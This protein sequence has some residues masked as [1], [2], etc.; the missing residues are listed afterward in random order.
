MSPITITLILLL[1]AI[2]LFAIE[3]IPV[4]IVGILLVMGLVLFGVLNVQEAVAGFG[5]D[6]IITIGGLFVLTGG[7][8]KTGL[9]DLFGRRL[10]RIAGDNEFVLVFLI[11]MVGT[12][13]STFMNNTT[14]T[15]ML[16]PFVL[17][18][19]QRSK[20]APSKL[21]MPLAFGTIM[22]GSCL[23]IG[24]S[25]NLAVS[26]ALTRY[27]MEPI[28]MFELTPVGVIVALLGIIYMLVIGRK[29]LPNRGG[30]DSLTEQYNIRDYISEL[31]VLPESP[32]VGK[33][34][35]ETNLNTD[36][37]LNV[38][39]IIRRGAKINA[40]DQNERIQRRDS[41]IVEGSINDILRVKDE[42]GLEIK[43]DFTLNDVVLEDEDTELFEVLVMR[44]SRF[45]GQ[46]LKTLRFR[47]A[48]NLTVL[49]INRHGRTFI[50]KLSAVPF[51][52]GDVLLV[53]GNREGIQ[54]LIA[55]REVMILKDLSEENV[56]SD[57]QK[58]AIL[59]FVVFLSLSLSKTVVGYD[60]PLAI[61][62]LCGVMVLLATKTIRYS[63]MYPMIDFRLLV[64]IACM[65]SFGVA[66]ESS[67]ADTYLADM[68]NL[69][70]G[71]FGPIAVLS[72][73]FILT[74]VL[75]QPMSNQAA[76]LVV[77]PVAIKAAVALG[78]N[79]RTFAIAVTFAASFSFI[80]PLE[81]ACVLVYTPGRYRFMD[82]VKIGS[83][84]TVIVFVV[85][86]VLVPIFWPF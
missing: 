8:V 22:G 55:N 74:V 46:N 75:T 45:V 30:E 52:F 61:A 25:T 42:A 3:K 39:G 67:G 6:I 16:I 49:A 38:L 10:F 57:K 73:F 47:Q 51:I 48:Y 53:Q 50:N 5:N 43:P 24:T 36:L 54:P 21:L 77:L 35:G 64:L 79:P 34:L 9:V 65:M 70:F 72:G 13:S 40:P 14:A 4:D 19:A 11:M 78:L 37:D 80:T 86:M 41:L 31:L 69:Y 56:R 12:I 29:M 81:P 28:S 82:F 85:S 2:I 63:E 27:G 71:Q 20:I 32:L 33:T 17:G 62:V 68:I 83:V 26:G 58:W 18:L 76:A 66:M 84:L 1:V 23:L 60:I 44:D 59:A 15:A 7:L